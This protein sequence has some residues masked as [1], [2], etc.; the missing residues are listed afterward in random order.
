MVT[1]AWVPLVRHFER[2]ALYKDSGA[3]YN[4]EAKQWSMPPGTNMRRIIKMHPEWLEDLGMLKRRIMLDLMEELE[5][6][7]LIR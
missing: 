3:I 4:G 6:W 7:P 1:K 5:N 2:R